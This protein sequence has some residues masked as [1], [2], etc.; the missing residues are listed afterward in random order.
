MGAGAD[1]RAAEALGGFR[2]FPQWMWRNT[3]ILALVDWLR[4]HNDQLADDD[5]R[6]LE[7]LERTARWDHGELPDTYPTDM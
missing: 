2:R 6:A 4:T 7:P 5:T 1:R 3:D